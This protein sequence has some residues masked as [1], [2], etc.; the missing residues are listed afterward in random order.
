MITEKEFNSLP[1]S[2]RRQLIALDVIDSIIAS[3][4]IPKTGSYIETSFDSFDKSIKESPKEKCEVCQLGALIISLCKTTNDLTY[5]DA[6]RALWGG[7]IELQYEKFDK[8]FSQKQFFYIESAFER[9]IYGERYAWFHPT[10][11]EG[12]FFEKWGD[13]YPKA[14]DRMIAIMYNI[15]RNDGTFILED[16]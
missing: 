15:I 16:I 6:E 11:E 3:S 12:E 2:V 4:Y 10:K 1:A 5:K 9:S 7:S 14:D 8:L 13:E